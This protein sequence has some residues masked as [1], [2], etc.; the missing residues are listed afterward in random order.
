MNGS[1]I[2]TAGGWTGSSDSS[3]RR[4]KSKND[5]IF[6][7]QRRQ[8]LR[9]QR[10]ARNARRAKRRKHREARYRRNHPWPYWNKR[11]TKRGQYSEKNDILISTN[12]DSNDSG[13]ETPTAAAS[14]LIVGAGVLL[15][16]LEAVEIGLGI[17][18]GILSLSSAMMSLVISVV[19]LLTMVPW[20]MI[21]C[22]TY[23]IL[24]LVM[25]LE[26]F[27]IGLGI[28]GGI[29][30]LAIAV[31]ALLAKL[32]WKIIKCLLHE[33]NDYI[34]SPPAMEQ[35]RKTKLEFYVYMICLPFM[36]CWASTGSSPPPDPMPTPYT[37][38]F[39]CRKCHTDECWDDII[40]R[41]IEDGNNDFCRLNCPEPD[42][43]ADIVQCRHCSYNFS[44]DN[45]QEERKCGRTEAG[46]IRQ[47]T[48][49]HLR[50]NTTCRE[51]RESRTAAS[52]EQESFL[53][54]I[55]GY[56]RDASSSI[57]DAFDC[58]GDGG[59]SIG[60]E[61]ED[62]NLDYN[63]NDHQNASQPM[64]A[65]VVVDDTITTLED[66]VEG[67]A[68]PEDIMAYTLNK[69]I[70]EQEEERAN[71]Y[72][73]QFKGMDLDPNSPGEEEDTEYY[74]ML[75]DD[76]ETEKRKVQLYHNEND[77]YNYDHFSFLDSREEKE[78]LTKDRRGRLRLCQNQLFFYQKYLLQKWS[79]EDAADAADAG[80]N[81]GDAAEEGDAT[82]GFAGLLYRA[83]K[84]NREEF[85]H[86]AYPDETRVMFRLLNLL[87]SLS[88]NEKGELIKYQ[89]EL[90]DLFQVG[91]M[92]HRVETIFPS[93]MNAARRLVLS[94]ANS[95][96]K[97]FPVPRVFD[98]ASHACVSLEETIRIAAGH[99]L[100]FNF[101][102]DA[103]TKDFNL[104]GLNGTKA[105]SELMWDMDKAM[106]DDG[107]DSK[108][109][110][111][112][113]IG[114]IYLWSDSFLRCFIK[115]KENSVWILTATICP[116]E[117][118][119]SNGTNTFV[120]AMGKS[121]ED[122]TKVIE[123]YIEE[124]QRLM[125]GFDIYFGESN[126]IGRMAAGML[127][128]NADR[129]ERQM[130][131]NTKKEG[132]Y[133]LVTGWAVNV[134]EEKFPSCLRCHRRRVLEMI[135]G[136]ADS[137]PKCSECLDW[138]LDTDCQEQKTDKAH[139]DYPNGDVEEEKAREH[140]PEGR[141]PGQEF[142]GPIKLSTRWMRKV[143][144]RAYY[145]MRNQRWSKTS[146]E[147][148][149]QSCNVGG[150]VIDRITAQA[151]YDLLN[152]RQSK[153]SKYEPK[154]W[155]LMDDCFERFRLPDLPMHALAHGIIPDVMGIVH[156]ILTHYKK[157]TEFI[158][159]ANETLND[160]ASFRLDYCKLKSLPKAAWVGENSMAYMRLLSY[161]YGMYFS[162]F[163]L[164]SSETE[165]TRE[166]VR[167]IKCMLN[168]LQA[169]MSVLMSKDNKPDQN[170]IEAVDNH[171][172]VFMS[173][174]DWLHKQYGSLSK[175]PTAGGLVGELSEEELISILINFG[176]NEHTMRRETKARLMTHVSGL[177]VKKL[178]E[179]CKE[180]PNL[181]SKGNK[182]ELQ[183]RLFG[184]LIGRAL[185]EAQ[186]EDETTADDTAADG[187]LAKGESMCWKKGN[188]LSFTV[189]IAKQI[190]YLG[191][192]LLI[193]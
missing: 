30:S 93:D 118:E 23:Y 119:K 88:E 185:G 175:K 159:F 166:T 128:W 186:D 40:V 24:I 191:S 79:L 38:K 180:L 144:R 129:P 111:N 52:D 49:A 131:T 125:K 4:R 178:Q 70:M 28:M 22:L 94:G 114:C 106:I 33:V 152:K 56:L 1:S 80:G 127:I 188:W 101:L 16:A 156:S 2:A 74:S 8:H 48:M 120:L 64:E 160:V 108:Q 42:C 100:K 17:V 7:K 116:P 91:R 68:S 61:E 170:T 11:I 143:A 35:R 138:T 27:E 187:Q 62:P 134:S 9:R 12:K 182:T 54:Q 45:T 154:V 87:L 172:K 66:V 59:V 174:A 110:K 142:H 47:K 81:K 168:A 20:K 13:C 90:L 82:G 14:A 55:Q 18:H 99:G 146:T 39:H 155:A 6:L 165:K 53:G 151:K 162:N 46:L 137:S 34:L 135:G 109:R 107:Q 37:Q 103:K 85:S 176:N 184:H 84:G 122:H 124:C 43:K 83:N 157:Y 41:P 72:V 183:E 123:N 65:P 163:K 89:E 92:R 3:K 169:L 60:H 10:F 104:D 148:Y 105:A 25:A 95:I 115:Q 76:A 102:Y 149:L 192:L 21:K 31:A 190:D 69:M 141:L 5:G 15:M 19:S 75:I 67:D 177:T 153:P 32:P 189:N 139:A 112:T 26:A 140:A 133:G 97:N 181:E 29:L 50:K 96:L 44:V 147:A 150:A 158:N 132:T 86:L 121:G 145:G 58:G 164:S 136:T 130:I 36:P 51:A 98:I 73:D 167:N 161:I 63:A 126:E 117:S 113:N 179:K 171:M 173:S 71:L 193:W 77:Q 78:K 57:C